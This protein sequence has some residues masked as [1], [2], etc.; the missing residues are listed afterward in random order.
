[1]KYLYR[2]QEYNCASDVIVAV[3]K[4]QGYFKTPA[5]ESDWTKL[6]VSCVPDDVDAEI[7]AIKEQHAA[8]A[9]ATRN[10]LLRESD[11]A[12]SPDA[13]FSEEEKSAIETY[14]KALW[15]LPEQIG[16]PDK[17]VWPDKPAC[18]K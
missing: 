10:E 1:M 2:G 13:K 6:G 14:R 15:D 7:K 5:S 9:L 3:R 12:T 4:D 11:F 18:L 17:I 8:A 16:F